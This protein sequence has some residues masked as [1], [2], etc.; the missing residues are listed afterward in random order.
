MFAHFEEGC[1]LSETHYDAESGDKY[2]DNSIIPPLLRVEETNAL[3]S[4]NDSDDEPMFTEMLEDINDKIQSLP[5][6]NRREVRYKIC[7]RIQQGQPEWK[8]ALK[9][10]RN[11]DKVLYKV[12]KT[13]VKEISKYLPLGK[14]GSEI[15]HFIP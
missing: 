6:V 9:A 15:S 5:N 8:G 11:M 3:D 4:V 2:V 13:F 7:D 10:T 1:L 14:S 12:F